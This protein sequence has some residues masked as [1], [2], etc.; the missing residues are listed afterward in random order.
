MQDSQDLQNKLKMSSVQFK[1]KFIESF[2]E[3]GVFD[4]IEK[5]CKD[6]PEKKKIIEYLYQSQP[7]HQEFNDYHNCLFE[8]LILPN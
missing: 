4:T 5:D 1:L 3:K 8:C 6:L 7:K 2:L